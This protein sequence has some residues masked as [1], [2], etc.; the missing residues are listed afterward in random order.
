MSSFPPPVGPF[1]VAAKIGV[2]I[3]GGRQQQPASAASVDVNDRKPIDLDAYPR[4]RDEL[5]WRTKDRSVDTHRI[6]AACMESRLNLAQ[7]RWV[8]DQDSEL[9][10]RVVEFLNRHPPV[11]D[12]YNDWQ[13]LW[14]RNSWALPNGQVPTS[15]PPANTRPTP[16]T[17]FSKGVG[18]RAREL[19]EAVTREVVCGYGFPDH[20]FYTYADGVWSLEDGEIQEELTLL[21][22]N[23][24]RP[25]HLQVVKEI[26]RYLRTTERITGEPLSDFVNVPNG[27]LRWE[28]GDLLPHMAAY[29]ST[30][31]VPVEFVSGATCP[32]FEKFLSEVL[33]PDLFL[34]TVDSP[35]F[36]WELIGYTLYSGNPL[37]CAVLLW[38]DGRNGKGTLI[39][40]LQA[41]LGERNYST[42]SLHQLVENKFRAATLYGKLANLAGDLDPK[43]LESTALF[44][45][46]TGGDTISAEVKFGA[47]F[48]FTPWALPFYSI[49]K[50]FGSADSS[51]GWVARWV[52]VPFPHSFV[53]KEDN[54]LTAK[55]T[56]ESELRGIL[57]RGATALPRL[58]ARGRFAEPRSLVDAKANFILASDAI[59]AWVDED[60]ELD[61]GAWIARA[62]LYKVYR[63]HTIN[64][65]PKMLLSPREFYNRIEQIAGVTA[66]RRAAA[67]GFGGIRLKG[68]PLWTP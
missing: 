60:C 6:V 20:R 22:G 18:L 2:D 29:R 28:T 15:A 11:D 24:Y 37:H 49:N 26:L 4:V 41:L 51:E 52:V 16:G 9:E 66:V 12:V 63:Q 43:W 64:D 68:A 1:D 31:Q 67:R 5:A 61:P 47:P 48:D 23:R 58:M 54:E 35:G 3:T 45:Q 56:S 55:L 30:V 21:L 13:K 59:R 62:D 8:I 42:V 33:P 32:R 34:P 65:N 25:T 46:I 57:Y 14:I 44:K 36:I 7:T 17:F 27:M 53:G 38:G 19:A 39:R 50:P 40:V 10:Q